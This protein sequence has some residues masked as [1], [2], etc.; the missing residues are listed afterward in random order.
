MAQEGDQCTR[1]FFQKIAKR[2]ASK[3][4]FH[5]TSYE[6]RVCIDDQEVIDEF[7]EYY[8][9]L[10]GGER[11]S[12]YM[13]IRFLRPWARYILIAEEASQ[14]VMPITRGEVTVAYF[15]IVED[16]SPSLDG[17]SASFYKA[18]WLII[19]EEVTIAVMGFFKYGRILKQVNTTL[20]AL[21]PKV[22][23]PVT[24]ADFRSISYCNV[25]YKAITKIIV[26]KLRP[27]LDRMI[28][29]TQ[30]AFIPGRSISENILLAQELFRDYNQQ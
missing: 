25:L 17:Y 7:V 30:N 26:Q 15:D 3:C 16:K 9:R 2:R 22:Q 8:Q 23:P 28:S 29:S 10:L 4:I 11:W 24:V 13:D 5:I 19:S 21:I 1:V 20:L 14:L 27:L 18:T 6:G 12:S